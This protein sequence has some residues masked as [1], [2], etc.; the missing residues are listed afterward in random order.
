MSSCERHSL[1]PK[2]A[3]IL[4]EQTQKK[5]LEAKYFTKTRKHNNYIEETIKQKKLLK[6]EN[7]ITTKKKRTDKVER[8]KKTKKKSRMQRK[9][10]GGKKTKTGENVIRRSIYYSA[11]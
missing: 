9:M 6:H 11:L 8:R 1:L 7:R 5:K 2:C 10:W 4:G 3:E